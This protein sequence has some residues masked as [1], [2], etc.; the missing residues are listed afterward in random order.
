MI[1]CCSENQIIWESH[2]VQYVTHMYNQTRVHGNAKPSLKAPPTI[3]RRIPL[4]GPRFV[5]PSYLNQRLHFPKADIKPEVTYLKPLNVVHPFYYKN[6]DICPHCG[7]SDQ[8]TWN[9][10]TATGHREVHGLQREECALGFQLRCS[11]CEKSGGL[12]SA[13]EKKRKVEEEQ[14]C[15]ATT[16]SA[17]WMKWPFWD[18]PRLFFLIRN[19]W[20]R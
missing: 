13:S 11:K 10:W 6:L 1:Q 20:H 4:Y 16:T 12:T 8:T 2:V 15:F 5:P 9:S 14:Y 7:T 17:F 19:C 3:D 18:I